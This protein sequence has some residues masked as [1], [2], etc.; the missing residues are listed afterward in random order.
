MIAA[1]KT[2]QALNNNPGKDVNLSN[3]GDVFMLANH[4]PGK[5]EMQIRKLFGSGF[6]ELV[7][8]LEPG[9]WHGTGVL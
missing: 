8:E 9:I 7:F 4:Y 3:V 1:D 5:T 2:L 6:T